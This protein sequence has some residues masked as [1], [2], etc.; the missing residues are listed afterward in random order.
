MY[1]LV[2]FTIKQIARPV[3]PKNRSFY[4]CAM[5]RTGMHIETG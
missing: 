5:A 3:I 1:V 4:M 2:H